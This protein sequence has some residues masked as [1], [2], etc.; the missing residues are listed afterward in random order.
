MI[1]KAGGEPTDDPG[2]L[3][4]LA[5]QQGAAVGGDVTAVNVAR[6]WRGPSMGKSR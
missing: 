3:L 5:Q 1:R 6:T 2:E 4:G